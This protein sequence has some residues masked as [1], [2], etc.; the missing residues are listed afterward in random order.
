MDSSQIPLPSKATSD[1][2]SSYRET[3]L[4]PVLLLVAF[5]LALFAQMRW[6]SQRA[7]DG[8]A[9]AAALLSVPM[10]MLA[11]RGVSREMLLRPAPI[12][13]QPSVTAVT[14]T[15]ERWRIGLLMAAVVATLILLAGLALP[16]PA[17]GYNWYALLWII[18]IGC[19]LAAFA[20]APSTWPRLRWPTLAE[21]RPW[22]PL[23]GLTLVAL[24]LRVWQLDAMPATLGGDEGSQGLEAM[25]VLRGEI[26]NPFSTGWL[27]VPTMSF[28]FNA[29]TIAL[30]G[31]TF[32]GLRLPWALIGTLTI[33][34]TYL[35]VARLTSPGLALGTAIL[36]TGFHY[37]L[38]FS[39]LGSNQIADG[40]FVALMLLLLYRGYDRREPLAWG[41]SGMVIGLAHYFY[42][43]ARL[44]VV[45]MIAVLL[46]LLIRDGK[47]LW[48]EQQSGIVALFSVGL[49][50]AAPMIQ[51]AFRFP[52]D[53]NAR[54]NAVGVFQ[55]GWLEREQVILGQ[56]ALEI[57]TTQFWKAILLY[58][59]IS[60]PTFWY[61]APDP[62]FGL[63]EGAFFI[64][65]LGYAILHLGNRR[66]FPLVAWWG[67]A[68]IIGG[69]LTENPPSLQ[70]L[71]TTAQPA[72][73]FVILGLALFLRGIWAAMAV[74]VARSFWLIIGTIA[75]VLS[76]L[77]VRYYVVD[78]TPRR[79]YGHTNSLV[80]TSMADYVLER[81]DP[82]AL[83]VFLGAPRMYYGFGTILY[84]T[85]ESRGLDVTEPL[86]APIEGELA[87]LAK[88][89]VF[90][91]LPER[92]DELAFIT[93]RFPDGTLEVVPSPMNGEPLFFVYR[94][95]M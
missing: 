87:N 40:L 75:L 50:T 61:G 55:S 39:R 76:L 8:W 78:Y 43:G 34:V 18:A 17:S 49:V 23:A 73:F 83:V 60:D 69:V 57:M 92:R 64:L 94:P 31:H 2:K 1:A 74:P 3:V 88:P 47:R 41:L 54:V 9:L 80:A 26:N 91:L 6:L 67:G 38:H 22:M 65:G 29:P 11:L 35:L 28:Y 15:G 44:T 79:I 33:P 25:K 77:S 19:S 90:I 53:F 7:F 14:L 51:Y 70:R 42:A 16:A 52:D 24:V 86:T 30:F 27:G 93:P 62:L 72:V 85:G 59:A 46:L 68:V 12:E 58:N 32:V 13:T 66:L 4:I 81:V 89:L 56:S 95:D 21:A 36:L 5:G 10:L 63:V 82:E 48:R 20:P 37:H 45:L 84:L 71:I